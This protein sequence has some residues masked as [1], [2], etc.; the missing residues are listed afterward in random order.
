MSELEFDGSDRRLWS[1]TANGLSEIIWKLGD[2]S[3][4]SMHHLRRKLIESK[5]YPARDFERF[6]IRQPP[7]VFITYDWRA[8]L[9]D[10]VYSMCGGLERA[11]NVMQD[12]GL[13]DDP[14]PIV[15]NGI[16]IWMDWIFIDQNARDIESELNV[17]P[18]I[19]D[20]CDVHYVLS[21]SATTRAWCCY[22]IARFNQRFKDRPWVP[23][24]LYMPQPDY[25]GWESLGAAVESDK[26]A[27]KK[28]IDQ[29]YPGGITNFD[30]LMSFISNVSNDISRD[31]TYVRGGTQAV[32]ALENLE[33]AAR[34]WAQ[35]PQTPRPRPPSPLAHLA[36]PLA[37]TPDD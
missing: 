18:D 24:S 20:A 30:V 15:Y 31:G 10:V 34:R 17:L 23:R 4:Y 21:E 6:C 26:H 22:E 19:I 3:A 5:I 2:A 33:A 28:Q 16:R 13:V 8:N 11:G 35:R 37:F 36:A 12:Q 27:L 29:N 7:D 1:T 9:N 25:E 14:L 32:D